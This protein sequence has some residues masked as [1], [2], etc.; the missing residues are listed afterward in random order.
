MLRSS[1]D[2]NAPLPPQKA[3]TEVDFRARVV[4]SEENSDDDS[5]SCGQPP[6]VPFPDARVIER[7]QN[8]GLGAGQH[9][10]FSGLTLP[11]SL[12]VENQ[13]PMFSE[14]GGGENDMGFIM[15]LYNGLL[16]DRASALGP[17][18]DGPSQ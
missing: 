9:L 1:D 6:P 3:S 12:S 10:D 8:S 17:A 18:F 2:P 4:L 7:S 14:I 13:Y 11:T 16:W 5:T 15:D